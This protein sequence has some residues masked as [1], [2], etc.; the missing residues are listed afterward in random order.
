MFP[1]QQ[2][3]LTM[4]RPAMRL[5]SSIRPQGIGL[6]LYF[7]YC[8]GNDLDVS[9][10]ST[11]IREIKDYKIDAQFTILDAGYLS[12]DKINQ[13]YDRGALLA[14]CVKEN[15]ISDKRVSKNHPSNWGY[16][17]EPGNLQY[18]GCVY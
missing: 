11:M 7:R 17:G 9:T 15:S 12:D 8:P 3:A 18:R 1:I 13:L 4:A 16:K 5:G 2:S 6:P 10:L 14:S